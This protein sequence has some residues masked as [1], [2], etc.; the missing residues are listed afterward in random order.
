MDDNESLP[1]FK[2]DRLL[3]WRWTK[4]EDEEGCYL[5]REAELSMDKAPPK[6]AQVAQPVERV[7]Q[8]P[9]EKPHPIVEALDRMEQIARPFVR[10]KAWVEAPIPPKPPKREPV[11]K[12]E[13]AWPFD[14]QEIPNAMRKEK[15][16]MAAMLMEEWFAGRLNYSR[17]DKDQLKEID[18]N[19]EYY[20][21]DM[22]NRTSIKM[23]WVLGYGRAKRQFEELINERI[24]NNKAYEEIQQILTPYRRRLWA[25]PWEE[26]DYDIR[27]LHRK[28]QFQRIEVESTFE[29][30]ATQYIRRLMHEG[31]PDDLTGSLGA[32]NL[33]AAIAQADFDLDGKSATITHIVVYV[34]DSYSFEGPLDTSSQYLGHWSQDGVIIVPGYAAASAAKSRWVDVPVVTGSPSNVSKKGKVRYPIRNCSFKA[35]QMKHQRGGDFIIYSDFKPIRLK[36]PIKVNFK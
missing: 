17:T 6:L 28:F 8:A 1:Y 9:A 13:K 23:D 3:I 14:I 22:I 16:P 27:K 31:V 10:F 30:K 29:Q 4:C 12:E 25:S 26:C 15:M 34:R 5:V 18:Q 7:T 32:F 36:R 21:E 2:I 33:Y 19:G 35:W 24:Y 11:K 20:S